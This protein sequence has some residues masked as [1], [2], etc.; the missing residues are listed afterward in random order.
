M[1]KTK[2]LYPLPHF[3]L[4]E[5]KTAIIVEGFID[6]IM[7]HQHGYTNTLS[8]IT[9]KCSDY[10][11]EMMYM[12]LG[13]RKL[14]LMLDNDYA[15]RQGTKRIREMAGKSFLVYN[16]AWKDGYN[17]PGGTPKNEIEYMLRHKKLLNFSFKAV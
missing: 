15:G 2:M 10:Q 7:M 9:A 1:P 16:V 12:Q 3:V 4:P 6:A 17:D 14:V 13:I 8:I 11:L 5:D